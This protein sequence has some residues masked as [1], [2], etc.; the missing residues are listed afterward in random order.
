MPRA[1]LQGQRVAGASQFQAN[2]VVAT[3]DATARQTELAGAALSSL[4]TSAYRIGTARQNDIN[5]AFALDR[6]NV[7][8]DMM[9]KLT[10]DP[11]TGYLNLQGEDAIKGHKAASEQL[12]KEIESLRG[13]LENDDQRDAFERAAGAMRSRAQVDIDT[14]L[15]KQSRVFLTSRIEASI[16]QQK[17]DWAEGESPKSEA[18]IKTYVAELVDMAGAPAEVGQAEVKRHLSEMHTTRVGQLERHDDLVAYMAKH[19]KK[20]DATTRKGIQSRVTRVGQKEK[21][22][23]TAEKVN[24]SGGDLASKSQQLLMKRDGFSVMGV[25]TEPT[26]SF[27]VWQEAQ[28]ELE[29]MDRKAYAAENRLAVDVMKDAKNTLLEGGKLSAQQEANLKGTGQLGFFAAWVRSGQK[30]ETNTNGHE[31]IAE[32][33]TDSGKRRLKAMSRDDVLRQLGPHM[34]QKDLGN[35]LALHRQLNG[36]A[37]EEDFIGLDEQDQLDNAFRVSGIPGSETYGDIAEGN[38]ST[39]EKQAYHDLTRAKEQWEQD[40]QIGLQAMKQ[41]FPNKVTRELLQMVLADRAAQRL[42]DAKGDADKGVAMAN[43]TSEQLLTAKFKTRDGRMIEGSKLFPKELGPSARHQWNA[44]S[45]EARKFVEDSIR[46]ELKLPPNAVVHASPD[47]VWSR[48]LALQVAA[49]DDWASK[50]HQ[51]QSA[52]DDRDWDEATAWVRNEHRKLL[53]GTSRPGF[54]SDFYHQLRQPGALVQLSR[55]LGGNPYLRRNEASPERG[56]PEITANEQELFYKHLVD[57]IDES[58]PAHLRQRMTS[59]QLHKM[60]S[61]LQGRKWTPDL[62]QSAVG[63]R[64]DASGGF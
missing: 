61:N 62:P 45:A 50:T 28:A 8:G 22:R 59:F 52:S 21:G 64:L 25:K 38:R 32:H 48:T 12:E 58:M 4:G 34:S 42:P 6:A 53:N 18:M 60:I 15:A 3:Q 27:E 63:S 2:N 41:K 13:S 36:E 5:T 56:G 55:A 11:K 24:A 9:R 40:V 10:R 20:I 37:S 31:W 51:L 49:M 30:D 19:G 29:D 35:T 17:S 23:R 7:A 26:I 33:K 47:K 39:A 57:T 14:H 43:A 46:R 44:A 16:E 1:P 54:T